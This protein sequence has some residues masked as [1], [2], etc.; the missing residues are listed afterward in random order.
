MYIYIYI[1]ILY[2]Y[3]YIY[4]YMYIYTRSPSQDSRLFGRRPWKVLATAYEK[5]VPEQPRPW[6]KSCQGLGCSGTFFS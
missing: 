3:I 6:R 4:I 5:K 2:V 1:C